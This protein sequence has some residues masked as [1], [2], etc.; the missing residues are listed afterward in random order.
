MFGDD[1]DI[2]SERDLADDYRQGIEAQDRLIAVMKAELDVKD[3]EIVKLRKTV[4]V[5]TV[6]LPPTVHWRKCHD[7]GTIQLHAD[8]IAPYVN[9]RKCRSQDTRKVTT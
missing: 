1:E 7:C 5:L 6:D 8:N 4:N 2:R 9:C 3:A